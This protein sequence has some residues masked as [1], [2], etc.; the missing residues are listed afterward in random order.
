MC[1]TTY[2]DIFSLY[3]MN[4]FSLVFLTLFLTACAAGTDTGST[5][6]PDA[7]QSEINM[8]QMM[9]ISVEELRNQTL[10]EHMKMMQKMMKPSG[11][12]GMKNVAP[13]PACKGDG[14]SCHVAQ[15]PDAPKRG[16]CGC[17]MKSCNKAS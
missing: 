14:C 12:T 3:F 16:G 6:P 17:G 1:C 9:G 7:S 11:E 5:N 15:A 13:Y 2:Y 4:T 10:E 8:A